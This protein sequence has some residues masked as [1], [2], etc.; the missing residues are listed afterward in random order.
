MT[1]RL[2]GMCALVLVTEV[3]CMAAPSIRQVGGQAELG[4][5]EIHGVGAGRFDPELWKSGRLNILPDARHPMIA[6]R[7]SGVYRNIYAPAAVEMENGWR[8]FYGAWDGVPTGNDRIYSVETKDFLDFDNRQTVI[9]HGDFIHVCN[10]SAVR[11]PDGSFRLMCTAYPDALGKNKPSTYS[12]PDGLTWNGVKAPYPA[13]MSDIIAIDGYE[14]YADADING[15]N[16]V[17]YEDG[18]YRLY[19]NSFTD[20]GRVY[21][22]TSKDGKNYRFEGK[23]LEVGAVVNDVKK[24]VIGGKPWYLMG[25]HMNRDTLWYALSTDGMAFSPAQEL[26]KNRDQSDR[27]IVAI[28]W[29]VKGDRLLG[30]VYG[31]GEVGELN[32]NRLFARWLQKKVV[33]VGDDGTTYEPTAA[34]GPD[35]QLLSVPTGRNVTGHF[36]VYGDDGS[37]VVLENAPATLMSGGVYVIEDR[38]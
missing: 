25:L 15:M 20:F 14:K 33:F 13:R 37:T 5:A 9:E 23:S 26:I 28:G 22:A 35:R 32:R 11:L 12:S 34:L 29:V 17:F 18:V 3:M 19:F 4:T 31:A 2:I 38:D 6:P 16:V 27:Y 36:A 30:F 8:L 7:L 1:L 24:F 21:R 10:V